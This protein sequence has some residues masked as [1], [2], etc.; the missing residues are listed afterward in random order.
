MQI[1]HYFQEEKEE[2]LCLHKELIHQTLF[3]F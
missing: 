1:G 3:I 2:E